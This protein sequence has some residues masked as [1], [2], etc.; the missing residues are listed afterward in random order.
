MRE[1]MT[2]AREPLPFDDA[3]LLAEGKALRALAR[4]LLRRGDDAD[5]VVQGAFAAAAARKRPPAHGLGPWLHGTVR[6]LARMLRR[7]ELRR[8]ARE[9]RAARSGHEG[10]GPA[11][12]AQQAE[13]VR[14]VAAV[15]HAL[16]EP[17]RSVV[18]L[19]YW[20]DLPP[21]AIAQRL[22][23]PRNTVR[24]QLQRGLALLRHRLDQRYRDRARWSA[25]LALLGAAMQGKLLLLGIA[26]AVAAAIGLTFV[27]APAPPPAQGQPVAMAPVTPADGA[28]LGDAPVAPA[29]A[30]RREEVPTA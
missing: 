8:T 17:Y 6:H 18:L 14:D 29:A 1:G 3:R 12:L 11:V 22:G 15:V 13:I 16:P 5:D 20:R 19:R 25:P 27:L 24:S 7:S 21:A 10:D 4:S 28:P 9:R 23:V 26:L 30:A 2:I